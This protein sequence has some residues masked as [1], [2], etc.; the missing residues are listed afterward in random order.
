MNFG[1]IR[2]AAV[3]VAALVLMGCTTGEE[4]TPVEPPDLPP[5]DEVIDDAYDREESRQRA[6]ALL[7]VHEDDVEESAALRIVRRGDEH[8]AV[9]MDLRPGR[10][11]VELD[12]RDDGFVVTRVVVETADGEDPLVVE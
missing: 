11:N 5:V 9:T 2:F 4:S 8:F 12:E 10:L 6:T 7:G 1:M 3:P